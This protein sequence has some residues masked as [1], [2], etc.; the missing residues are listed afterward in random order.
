MSELTIGEMIERVGEGEDRVFEPKL[1]DPGEERFFRIWQNWNYLPERF[2][3]LNRPP[4]ETAPWLGARMKPR[5]PVTTLPPPDVRFEGPSDE[6][7]DLYNPGSHVFFISDRLFRLIEGFD[8]GSLEHIE[9]E[10]RAEDG[11]LPFHAVMPVRVLEAIDTRRT[12][13]AVTDKDLAGW[14]YRQVTFPEGLIFDNDALR[15]VSS[16]SDVDAPGWYWSK[17]L[18]EEAKANG[19]QGLYAN[20]VASAPPREV[21]NL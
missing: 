14:H 2:K 18:L 15:D 1:T 17:D 11:T 7:V 10:L 5:I 9:F 16:F 13:V 12:A 4:G 19:I 8:P 3:W 21:I 6:V 20:S